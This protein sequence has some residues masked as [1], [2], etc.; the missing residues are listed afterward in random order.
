MKR[1]ALFWCFLLLTIPCEAQISEWTNY[2]AGS[3]V[4]S[5]AQEGEYLW[6]AGGGLNQFNK[7]TGENVNYNNANSGLPGNDVQHVVVDKIGNKWIGMYSGSLVKFDG[8][9]WSEFKPPVQNCGITGIVIDTKGSIWVGSWSGGL[10]QFKNNSW[11]VYNNSNSGLPNA[12]IW[13]INIDKHD[14]IW[15]GMNGNLA[16]FDGVEWTVFN[17]TNSG[18]P[19]V[20]VSCIAFDNLGNKLIG[21]QQG[22]LVKFDDTNW[23]RSPLADGHYFDAIAV[24]RDNNIWAGS[25]NGDK[26]FCIG[27]DGVVSFSRTGGIMSITVDSENTK[28]VGTFLLGLFKFDN[29]TWT[30]CKTGNSGLTQDRIWSIFPDQKGNIWMGTEQRGI[31]RFD[32]TSWTEFPMLNNS[33]RTSPGV[34]QICGDKDG[35]VWMASEQGV[36]VFDGSKM[37][38][39]SPENSQLPEYFVRSIAIDQ[40]G[41]KW[42]G[43]NTK[44]LV[45]YNSAQYELFNTANSE[46]PSDEVSALALDQHGSLWIGFGNTGN[47]AKF[48]GQDWVIYRGSGSRRTNDLFFDHL[49]NLWV[50]GGFCEI[51]SMFDGA[52]WTH[53]QNLFN[54]NRVR[55]DD[56]NTLWFAGYYKG[57][58][59]LKDSQ[60][61]NISEGN[62]GLS[63]DMATALE[64]DRNGYLWIGTYGG[65]LSVLR[66]NNH[67][68][69]WA[70]PKLYSSDG[71]IVAE[72]A[73]DGV[74]VTG[75]NGILGGFVGDECRSAMSSG[76]EGPS[77]KFVFILRCYSNQEVGE[78]LNFKYFDPSTEKAYSISE[79]IPF[80]SNM[81]VGDAL[82]PTNLNA[83]S[84]SQISK[85]LNTGWTWFSLNVND[86]DM[87]TAH[88]LGDLNS[89]EGDYIRNQTVSSTYYNGA[90]WFGELTQIDPKEMYK[91][92]L[93]AT[94]TLKFAGIPL[95]PLTTPV[96]I[97]TGWNWIGYI[98]Q[99]AKPITQVLS[100]MIPV[101]DDYIK[102]QTKSST[103]YEGSGWFG[104]LLN[105]EPLDGYMLKTSH[106]G[107]LTYPAGEPLKLGVTG[108]EE[109][110][111]LRLESGTSFY[112]ASFEHSG[113]ITATIYLDGR[114]F[115]SE[116]YCLYSVVDGE[117]RGVSRGLWFEPGQTWIH[118]HL[119]YSNIEEG[120]TIWFRLHNKQSDT[121][122][123]FEEF[124]VFKADM[125]VANAMDP[126]IL[127]NS[128]LLNPTALNRESILNVYPNPVS[129]LASV[130]YYLASDQPVTIQIVD[131]SGRIVDELNM[132]K[133]QAG[134]HLAMWDTR[135]LEQGSYFVRMKHEK[136]V[137][138][139]MLIIR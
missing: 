62:S 19:G 76:I 99:S 15:I 80:E 125:L 41:N 69:W 98:P 12:Y 46:M 24:D 82:N 39:L 64:F 40:H 138:K 103:F 84:R 123:Q 17:S 43:M 25:I 100:T 106:T 131:Y 118:N 56:N 1:T 63:S 49:G 114:N 32:G 37:E 60:W 55:E 2:T 83:Y 42:F 107:T 111:D 79:T 44:G 22:G 133:Q 29:L 121:W 77:G 21:T 45:K 20:A 135:T 134:N 93:S 57:V 38:I 9:S 113:Q 102:N 34:M 10:W 7:L 95:D 33:F 112:P 31:V 5:I 73:I 48:T 13:C 88:V 3:M 74:I 30:Y 65:G 130:R 75:G 110:R 16:K 8:T 53:F 47:I 68:S 127:K 11:T 96:T 137:Y 71:E 92:K 78:I 6:I 119:T 59:I 126:F 128:T 72:V 27:S 14:N 109:T 61:I 139:K 58:S 91:I 104:E 18:L 67:Y 23:I 124:V 136:S 89:R 50:S 115:N 97:K 122:Y 90:G 66:A 36:G 54:N 87:S 117:V 105:L 28:W 81:R 70:D 116:D 35:K 4:K 85:N 51:T 120:D 132:G 26:I 108:E 129:S 52:K 94:D 86:T 101:A